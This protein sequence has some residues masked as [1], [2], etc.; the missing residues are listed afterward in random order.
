MLSIDINRK[1]RKEKSKIKLFI[2]QDVLM[3]VL[4]FA[5]T[6]HWNG[7]RR[8]G[9]TKT[10]WVIC[11]DKIMRKDSNG[12]RVPKSVVDTAVCVLKEKRRLN[13]ERFFIR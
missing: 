12:F 9:K 4:V 5:S 2:S 3:K 8:Q 11:I 13:N 10:K 7:K 1:K 6:C